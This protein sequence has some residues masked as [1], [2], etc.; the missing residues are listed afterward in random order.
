MVDVEAGEGPSNS[1]VRNA[2]EKRRLIVLRFAASKQKTTTEWEH[3]WRF[4]Y[5]NSGMVTS[6]A[7]AMLFRSD[8]HEFTRVFTL[9][10]ER[11]PT[12]CGRS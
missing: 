4:R 8:T 6:L 5:E 3:R 9:L 12:D 1:A 2:T 7:R 11:L 10:K